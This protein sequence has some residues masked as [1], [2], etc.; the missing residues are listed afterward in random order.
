MIKEFNQHLKKCPKTDTIFSLFIKKN[1][2]QPNN[3]RN[4]FI[5][6]FL[7]EVPSI[8]EIKS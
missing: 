1:F 6:T 4:F 7:S 5:I 2:F 8:L 3:S